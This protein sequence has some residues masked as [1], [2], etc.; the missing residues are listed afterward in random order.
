MEDFGGCLLDFDEG[1]TRTRCVLLIVFVYL[2]IAELALNEQPVVEVWE[3]LRI[4][5]DLTALAG[6][7]TAG[8]AALERHR[9]V[10]GTGAPWIRVRYA[11]ARSSGTHKWVC[12]C[13]MRNV[14]SSGDTASHP[15]RPSGA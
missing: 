3:D 7:D 6:T 9:G 4:L 14:G 10:T 5:E 15:T 8:T 11:S 2:H 12:R 1:T 13:G